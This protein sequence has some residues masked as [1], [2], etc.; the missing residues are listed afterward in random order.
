MLIIAEL[1]KLLIERWVVG[2]DADGV[3]G[4]FETFVGG[5]D[6]DTFGAIGDKPVELGGGEL[7]VEVEI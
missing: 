2:E 7:I 6:D 4:D 1:E 3:V 5:F